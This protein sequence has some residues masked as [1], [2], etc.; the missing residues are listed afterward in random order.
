MPYLPTGRIR[1][2]PSG[3]SSTAQTTS[4]RSCFAVTLTRGSPD[5]RLALDRRDLRRQLEEIDPVLEH[6]LLAEL[7]RDLADHPLRV[8]ERPVRVVGREEQEP[9]GLHPF[10]RLRQLVSVVR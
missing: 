6:D 9:V 4:S 2:V 7:L 10:E 3:N 5:A 1:F 8:V